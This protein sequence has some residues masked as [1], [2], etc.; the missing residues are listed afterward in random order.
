[1]ADKR[2]EKSMKLGNREAGHTEPNM[3]DRTAG[4][5]AM[6]NLLGD[7]LRAYYNEVASEPVPAR[8]SQLLK[9]LEAASRKKN[10]G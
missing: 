4:K 2:P 1:M 8:F 10:P 3:P 6:H 9:E 5:I 7:K